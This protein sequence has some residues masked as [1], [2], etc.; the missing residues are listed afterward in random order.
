MVRFRIFC[1][2]M[3]CALFVA[4]PTAA[5][6]SDEPQVI[7][8][9]QGAV[10][11]PAGWVAESDPDTGGIFASNGD[12]LLRILDP[13]T[14]AQ[15]VDVDGWT[16]TADVVDQLADIL[17]MR[18]PRAE[19]N[20]YDGLSTLATWYRNDDPE[21]RVALIATEVRNNEFLAVEVRPEALIIDKTLWQ[22]NMII[23][24][25]S[26]LR[27]DGVAPAEPGA[28]AAAFADD[29]QPFS[30]TTAD[31]APVATAACEVTSATDAVLRVGPGL[32][33][34][35]I[36]YLNTTTAVTVSGR[37]V[38][39]DGSVWLQLD[40]T[41]AAP[42]SAANEIWVAIEDVETSGDCEQVGAVAAP[43]IIRAVNP[44]VAPPP[45]QEPTVGVETGEGTLPS[46]EPAAPPA[47]EP[48]PAGQDQPPTNFIIPQSG[49]WTVHLNANSDLSCE[50]TNNVVFPSSEMW[51]ELSWEGTLTAQRDGTSINMDGDLYV[52]QPPNYYVGSLSTDWGGN[53]QLWFNIQSPTLMSGWAT[54]NEVV[55]NVPCS[56]TT[57]LSVTRN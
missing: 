9:Q 17:D 26:T 11:L 13:A 45:A 53:I 38:T 24:G 16:T 46:G 6:D 20:F 34:S 57:G 4:L 28:I 3:F 14:V 48:P 30:A 44:P 12:I 5:Q 47:A 25:Y 23:G 33:R 21:E 56:A 43:P 15:W 1:L 7:T 27:T 49:I 52:F 54:V 29:P 40:R 55:D 18:V 2:L 50:G 32:N 42:Q 8:L 39:D 10:E 31:S 36:A 22:V 41:Q 51:E 19:I 35:S 37:F